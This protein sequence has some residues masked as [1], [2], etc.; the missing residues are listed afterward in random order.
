MIALVITGPSGAGKS[1]AITHLSRSSPARFRL[2]VSATTRPPR[3]GEVN[4]RDYRFLSPAAFQALAA[5]GQ[6]IEST[7]FNGHHYGTPLPPQDSSAITVFDVDARGTDFFRSCRLF[8]RVFL[9]LVTTSEENLRTRLARRGTAG[10]ELE[11]RVSSLR[12]FEDAGP[13]DKVI[14]NDRS[15]AEFLQAVDELRAELLAAA[16]L[17]G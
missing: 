17:A 14:R 15:Q 3:P 7:L 16:G 5:H 8:Q 13:F 6:L 11:R 12:D 2:S 10:E 1:T 9:C 4:G